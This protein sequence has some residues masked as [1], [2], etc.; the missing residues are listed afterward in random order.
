[1]RQITLSMFDVCTHRQTGVNLR[2]PKAD[3]IGIFL[4]S[5]MNVCSTLQGFCRHL[6]SCLPTLSMQDLAGWAS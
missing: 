4:L 2:K 1:M 3:M 6:S 5:L